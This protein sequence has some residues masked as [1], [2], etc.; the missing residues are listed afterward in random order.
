MKLYNTLTKKLEDFKPLRSGQATIYSCGPTV[1]DHIHIGNLRAFI[2]ADTL[3]RGLQVNGYK[4]KHV[5]NYTDVD[6]KIITRS[7]REYPQ[8]SPEVALKQLTRKYSAVFDEDMLQI[9][10]DTAAMTFVR[11]TDSMHEM[12]DLIKELYKAKIAYLADDGVYFSIETYRDS[13]KTYGQ[14]LKLDTKNTSSAR[15]NNDEYDKDS[16]H[17]FALWKLHKGNEPGWEFE[18]DGHNLFGR[19]GWH[20]ECSAMS[21]AH[22]GQPFDIHTG[23]VD[24]IFPHHENEI[25]QSTA[26]HDQY[27]HYFV[28]NEHLLVEGRKMSKSLD[29]FYTLADIEAKGY[30][31]LIFRMLALQAHYRSQL[32]FSW[33]SLEAAQSRLQGYDAMAVQQWQ[34]RDEAPEFDYSSAEKKLRQ[35]AANDLDTPQILV[36]LSAVAKAIEANGVKTSQLKEFG[37][38]LETADKL[39]A[40]GLT[41]QPDITAEQK[42]L[43][44]ERQAARQSKDWAKTDLLRD[45]LAQQGIAV[46]D[47][48]HGPIWSRP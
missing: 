1:Y 37:Q 5:M 23:G 36:E 4:T 27:A 45:R 13:G 44:K 29:N 26:T 38:F 40:L 22:L 9:G 21:T 10:N 25:A 14:L 2:T 32:N 41:E 30:D 19:P 8:D 35:H 34:S 3:R 46:R 28:H 31:P 33:E 15:I 12:Q 11:A 47:T 7:Q 42:S 6:D 39:L 18:L 24:L 43:L 16:V 20:I 48:A 17:D